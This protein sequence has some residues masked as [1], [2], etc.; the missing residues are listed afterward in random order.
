MR[1]LHILGPHHEVP[2][3][4]YGG[5]E[6]VVEALVTHQI[7]AGLDVGTFTVGSSRVPG[8][9]HWHF[10]QTPQ[11]LDEQG[12]SHWDFTDDV[13]HVAKAMAAARDYDVVHNHTEFALPLLG[14]HPVPAL[15]TLHSYSGSG[16]SLDRL[17]EAFPDTPG[18]AISASQRALLPP[19]N[20]VMATVHN[21]L[22]LEMCDVPARIGPGA[23]TVVFLGYVS[24]YK[25]PDIAVRA[26]AAAGRP[27][28]VAGPLSPSNRPFFDHDI[29]PLLD[30]D[31]SRWIGEVGGQDKTDL[32]RNAAV[33]LCPVRWNEPFGLTAVEAMAVG[34]P[35]VALRRGGLAET[36]EDDITGVLV[37][38]PDDLPAAIDRA[39]ALDREQCA[40]RARQRF[41]PEHAAAAYQ[42]L[43]TDLVE[44]D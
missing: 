43:Y 8:R 29:A 37:D 20:Q 24:R 23:P 13:V 3:I 1:V 21:P 18:V 11:R 14:P 41:A 28:I 32:L 34:T 26:A 10:P 40:R 15:T 39:A 44:R 12:H 42:R 36:V 22:P 17:V 2:T 30:G 4:G 9:R 31:R 35:V 7:A 6:R 25:G 16:G 27:V 38:D 5:T 19:A 33:L